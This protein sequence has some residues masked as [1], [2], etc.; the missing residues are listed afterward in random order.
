[1]DVFYEPVQKTYT[2]SLS[3]PLLL[4]RLISM[5][6]WSKWLIRIYLF[7]VSYDGGAP[8]AFLRST[9]HIDHSVA[10]P[11]GWSGTPGDGRLLEEQTSSGGLI[12]RHRLAPRLPSS[13]PSLRPDAMQNL[14]EIKDVMMQNSSIWV[15]AISLWSQAVKPARQRL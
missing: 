12:P 1:M 9:S 13:A 15:W 5:L 11:W 14:Q 2:V 8:L 10:P 3:P 7:P 4:W 6:A